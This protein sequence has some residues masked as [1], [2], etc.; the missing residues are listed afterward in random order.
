MI[1]ILLIALL[2]SPLS[3]SAQMSITTIGATDAA[4]CFRQAK[5]SFA[6]ST[7]PC[8]KAIRG[9]NLSRR[10][11]MKTYVNRGIIHNRNGDLQ[12]AIKDFNAALEI[13]PDQPEAWLNRGNSWFLAGQFNQAVEDYER[14]L[15]LD[16]Q[17]PWAA[18][19][20]IGLSY[21]ALKQPDRA[22]A[23]YE[24]ALELNPDFSKA[25]AKLGVDD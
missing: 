21:D 9:V 22:K 12:K 4:D 8:D 18:W 5:S 17:K 24:T 20:N 2:L 6:R 25:R 10:D 1:R 14:S 23:A 13:V 3:V 16:I 19:Y 7:K 11:K 15:E